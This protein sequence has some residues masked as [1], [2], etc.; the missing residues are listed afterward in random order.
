MTILTM[1]ASMSAVSSAPEKPFRF[2]GVAILGGALL[3]GRLAQAGAFFVMARYLDA[4]AMGTVA[5]LTVLYL[6]LFQLTNLGFDRYI[7]YAHTQ[8][9]AD[10][11]AT[12]DAV[13]TMQILRGLC[14]LVLSLPLTLALSWFPQ[15]GIGMSHAAGIAAVII[16]LSFVN[17]GLSSFERRGDFSYGSSSRGISA[18]FG[19]LA[20][21][22]LVIFWQDPWVYVIG[23]LASAVVLVLLS[24][25]YSQ[26]RP[27]LRFEAKRLR[28]VFAYGKHLLVIATVS[29]LASQGQNAY[30]GLIFG[31]AVL[32]AYFTWHRLVSL[33]GELVTQMQDRL[34]F[35]KAS[36]QARRQDYAGQAH[37]MGF[38]LTMGLLI[39]FYVFVWFHGDVLMTFV[40]GQRWTSYWWVGKAF[41][42]LG[43]FY[44]VAGTIT[45]F[46]LVK[47]PHLTSRLRTIE[48]LCGFALLLYLGRLYGIGGVLGALVAEIAAAAAIR[49]VILYRHI[50][51]ER[52]W[53]HAVT[54][55]LTLAAVFAPLL[56]WEEL[57]SMRLPTGI[58][59]AT[60]SLAVY[61]MIMLIVTGF[62]LIYRKRL[63]A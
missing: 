4:P 57:A 35:A 8:D 42:L 15:F 40:A 22:L 47:V 21:I 6:G 12:I 1:S 44:A 43:F 9:D 50:V 41:V 11:T 34:L 13:W 29:F 48:A 25:H 26:S 61:C 38:A 56:G 63:F 17:P 19:A 33:P 23:Q 20:T 55:L 7:V 52:R 27:R 60:I 31:P 62:G 32:G 53:H 36:E 39:P 14:V 58:N 2:K 54:V 59:A 30:V 51:T 5:L 10:L 28:D 49:I 24:H 18:A 46:A 3:A 37:L 16:L 45:P